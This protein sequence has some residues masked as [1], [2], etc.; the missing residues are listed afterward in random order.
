M[1]R[2]APSY[3]PFKE[4]Q[5]ALEFGSRKDNLPSCFIVVLSDQNWDFKLPGE[6]PLKRVPGPE[7]TPSAVRLAHITSF[8]RS[9][10]FLAGGRCLL[11]SVCCRPSSRKAAIR[12][13]FLGF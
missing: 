11:Y 5:S 10:S 3:N 1:E 6:F 4:Q 13:F 2:L 8:L 12:R 9:L 7:F